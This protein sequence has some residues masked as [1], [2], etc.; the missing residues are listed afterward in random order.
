MLRYLLGRGGDIE[1][2]LFHQCSDK[3]IGSYVQNIVISVLAINGFII[4]GHMCLRYH[5]GRKIQR[6]ARQSNCRVG[7]AREEA[8]AS[9]SS[10]SQLRLQNK[11][12]HHVTFNSGLISIL[13]PTLGS[14]VALFILTSLNISIFKQEIFTN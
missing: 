7:V 2:I 10:W 1:L 5:W 13:I 14:G 3:V 6:M 12:P 11:I 8:E 9:R 4:I